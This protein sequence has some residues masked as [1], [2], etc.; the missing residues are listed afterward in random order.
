MFQAMR[1]LLRNLMRGSSS[2]APRRRSTYERMRALLRDWDAL[3]AEMGAQ[4]AGRTTQ[5]RTAFARTAARFGPRWNQAERELA[6]FRDA[7][8]EDRQ[9]RAPE[10]ERTMA[11][12]RDLV[13]SARVPIEGP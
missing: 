12:L 11:E 4:V 13:A 10:L 6:A 7:P 8:V 3:F 2:A 9:R 1:S 5:A